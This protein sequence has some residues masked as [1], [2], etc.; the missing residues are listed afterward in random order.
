M[1]ASAVNCLK[2]IN[3]GRTAQTRSTIAAY[4]AS[5]AGIRS[6]SL[7]DRRLAAIGYQ[8]KLHGLEWNAGHPAIRSTLRGIGR[9]HG[10]HRQRRQAVALT[11]IEIKQLLK[12]CPADLGGARDRALLLLAFSGALRRSELVGLDH[13]D[14]RQTATGLRLTIRSSKTDAEAMGVELGIPRGKQPET[15]PVRALA[16]WLARAAIDRGPIFRKVDRWGHVERDRLGADGV[17]RIL[18]RR[19]QQAGLTV[20]PSER[21]SPHGLRAGFVTEAYMAGA[22]DEQIMAHS[23]HKDLKTMR[24]Y[25]RRARLVSDSPVKLLDI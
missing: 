11:S 19:A 6:R 25:V 1:H 20:D 17:R 22:R 14:I 23:R 9:T 7:L 8:H 24:G 3:I 16:D 21:L 4:L 12:V 15:C 18:R 10:R 13:D 5:L 2:L